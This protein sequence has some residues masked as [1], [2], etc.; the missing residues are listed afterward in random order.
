MA[1]VVD[2]GAEDPMD[3]VSRRFQ[4]GDRLEG[5]S[6]RFVF[7]EGSLLAKMC[8]TDTIAQNLTWSS[9][10]RYKTLIGAL[11]KGFWPRFKPRRAA[12]RPADFVFRTFMTIKPT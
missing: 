4:L 8:Y 10:G 5:V 1:E 12:A 2:F 7:L 6:V 11:A 9:S 3:P